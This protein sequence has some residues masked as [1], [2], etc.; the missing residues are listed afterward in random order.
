M[1]TPVP[2]KTPEQRAE[3]RA[4]RTAA[5]VGTTRAAERSD[6]SALA[7]PVTP[8]VGKKILGQHN[9][10]NVYT[11][12]RSR[13]PERLA[14]VRLVTHGLHGEWI[15]TL[16]CCACHPELYESATTVKP[17]LLSPVAVPISDPHHVRTRGAGGTMDDCVPLCRVHHQQA[18]APASGALSFAATY[19][20]DL[21]AIAAL[22]WKV[23]PFR[24]EG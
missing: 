4:F 9:G 16:L 10:L 7:V 14:A 21:Q 18:D 20:L 23:S 8:R 17:F 22:L 3:S 11:R 5:P 2:R 15:T 19:D 24:E 12:L 6:K 13:N 1:G